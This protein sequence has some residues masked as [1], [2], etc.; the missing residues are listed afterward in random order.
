[1]QNKRQNRH[2]KQRVHHD[3]Y[4]KGKKEWRF[5]EWRRKSNWKQGLLLLYSTRGTFDKSMSPL[6]SFLSGGSSTMPVT[7]GDAEKDNQ[8]NK[9]SKTNDN[10]WNDIPS[11]SV[12]RLLLLKR[13]VHETRLLY[14]VSNK[15]LNDNNILF[16]TSYTD[17]SIAKHW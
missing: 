14:R 8:K 5:K 10:L 1:M 15:Q 2:S 3:K 7:R 9:C 12:K 16:Q 6:L 17:K 13:W 4:Q 11:V